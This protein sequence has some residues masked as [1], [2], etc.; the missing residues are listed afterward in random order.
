MG[1]GSYGTVFEGILDNGDGQER[2]VL[3]RV[4][5]RVEGATEMAQMEHLMNVYAS[6]AAKGS[7][8]EFIG[9]CE[10]LPREAS[11]KLTEGLWLMWR[12]EGS[13]TLAYYL[14]RRD[15]LKALAQDL[16]V[17]EDI[18]V[19]VAMR[20]LLLGLSALHSAGLVHRDVK[21]LNIIASERDGRLKLI[22]LGAHKPDRFDSWSAGIVMMQLCLPGLRTPRGLNLFKVEYERADYDLEAWRN[23]CRWI[24][25]RD[26]AVLDANDGAGWSFAQALLQPR[27][28]TVDSDGGVQFVSTSGFQ[29][30]GAREALRHSFLRP[31][32]QHEKNMRR[33]RMIKTAS[34]TV[35]QTSKVKKLELKVAKGQAD[36]SLL[37]KEKQKLG[38]MQQQLEDLEEEK[39]KT[40]SRAWESIGQQLLRVEKQL[41]DQKSRTERQRL[42]VQRMQQQPDAGALSYTCK[43]EQQRVLSAPHNARRGHLCDCYS[44]GQQPPQAWPLS[45]EVLLAR[46]QSAAA[47]LAPEGVAQ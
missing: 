45:A 28:I 42:S 10:V 35:K 16:G 29:R 41:S 12:Y 31:A 22:D 4:K 19:P 23:S 1:E 30:M 25:K 2:V 47:G 17:P 11:H 6:K 7:I 8:A 26:T 9:Y 15:T 13:N 21:P 5:T 38:Q 39:E 24:S 46:V 37:A 32:A 40:A 33:A 3:K 27:S 36:A 34:A 18:V 14:R 44:S 20:Q 43:C